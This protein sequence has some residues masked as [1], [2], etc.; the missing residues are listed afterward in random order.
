MRVKAFLLS[1][2]LA[3]AALV[4]VAGPASAHPALTVT[5]SPTTVTA[6]TTTT[7]TISGTSNGSYT[8]ARIDVSATAGTGGTTGTLPSFT[9]ISGFGG[10]ITSATEAGSVDSLAL[11][12]LTN[13]QP[14]SYT[15][16]LT[17]D[18]ATASGTFTSRG[19]FYTSGGSTTGSVNGPVI[20]VTAA[21]PDIALS[22][23]TNFRVSLNRYDLTVGIDNVGNGGATGIVVTR[24]ITPAGLYAGPGAGCVGDSTGSLATCA[25]ADLAAGAS[26]TLANASNF[27]GLPVG[28]WTITYTATAPGDTNTAND[29]ATWSCTLLTGLVI[30]CT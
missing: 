18:S 15:L 27:A 1:L 6:G 9:T 22:K 4:A 14:F 23:V 5:A 20:T 30:T 10:G 26:T 11:P 28:T 25:I 19:Q 24:T 7:I 17:V 13:G 21:V 3:V 29:T 16:T 8:G 12:T 2:V